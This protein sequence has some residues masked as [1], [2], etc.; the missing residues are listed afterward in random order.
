M[1]PCAANGSLQ[2]SACRMLSLVLVLFAASTLLAQSG[3]TYYVATNGSDGNPGTFA[4]PWLTVQHAATTATAGAT[5]YVMGGVYNQIVSFPNSGTQGSPITFQ[6]YPGQ[7][8][9]LDGTGLAVSGT[10]GLITISGAR[11]YITIS[12]FEIRNLSTT[13]TS[14]VPCG[15]WITGSGTGVQIQNNLIHNIVSPGKGNGCGLFAY[16]TSQT[17]ISGLIVNGNEL[18]DLQT[19]ESESMTLN[20]NVTNFQVTNNLVH[21]NY[22]IGIDIIGYE[23]TGPTGYD[24]AMLGVVSGN[25]VYNIS[26]IVNSGET[27]EYDADGLYCDGCAYVTWEK[28]VVFQTDYGIETTSENQL[29]GSNGTDWASGTIGVGTPA[30]GKLPCYGMYNTVRNNLFYEANSCGMSIGGYAKATTKGGGSN[31]GGSSYHDVFVNNTLY[32]NGAQPGNADEGEPSGDY[33]IQYQVGSAQADYFENNVIYS[34]SPNIWIND[35][36]NSTTQTTGTGPYPAPPATLNYNSYFSMAGYAE[37]TSIVWEAFNGYTNFANWQSVTGEDANSVNADPQFVALGAAPPDFDTSPGSPAIGAGSSTSI[38]CSVGWCDPNGSSPNSIYGSTDFL[39]NPRTNG[40][41]IDIGAYQNTGVAVSNSISVNLSSLAN[42]LE[43]GQSTTLT[44]TVTATPGGAGVPS[45][46]VNFMVGSTLLQT[47]TLFPTSANTSAASLPLNA[48]QLTP[49]TNQ[50]TAVYSG[51]SIAPCCSPTEPPGGSQTP[52]PVYP[53]A[54]SS[55]I[56]VSFQGSPGIYNPA[57]NTSL[58]GSSQNFQWF[59]NASATAYWLDIGMEQGGNEY[60]SSG[61]LSSSTLS[62]TANS[63]PLNGST[64]WARWYYLIGGS[65]QYTDYSYTALGASSTIA[66]ITSPVNNSTFTSSSATFT[67]NWVGATGYWINVGSTPGGNQYF[68]SGNLGNVLTKTVNGLPTNGSTVYVTL[69]SLNHGVWL[70]NAYTYTAYN[71]AAGDAVMTTPAPNSTLTGS[72]VTFDWTAGSGATAYWI[73]IGSS[74]G[75]NNY[76]SS[77]NLGNVLT[78]TVSG[79]PTNGNTLYVTLYSLIG[80]TWSPNAYTYTAF[81]ASSATGMVTTPMPGSTLTSSTVT[82]DWTAGS[83]GPYSYWMDVGNTAGGNNYYSSGNLGNVTTTTVSGLPT[84]GSM[85]YVTLYTLISGSWVGNAYT[86]TALNSTSGLA[87]M[88]TPT[89]GTTISGTTATFNWSGDSNATAY[90]V[91]IGSSAG[92]N[93]IYSSGNLGTA[94]TTT[95]TTLPANG[96]EI[97]VSLYSYVGGQWVNNPVTYTSGP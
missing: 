15:V 7:T 92:G 47:Q 78:D 75:G 29:C 25:T 16:G 4:A 83:P 63:L 26:G 45:G 10:Q 50:L 37:G 20:G 97:Y 68:Q 60:Y 64:I 35:Y 77:G 89:P 66:G 46:T 67:W 22:N 2:H 70:S 55:S 39:G 23:K 79:L 12:G 43:P 32:D 34:G 9:I 48:V 80:G 14:A 82:F 17:P 88:Q 72:T 61:S 13:K 76:Y 81:S 11:S 52:N 95:V 73:D 87:T 59:G 6:S 18:Y 31:G 85:I 69:Y 90:W 44:A 57:N 53:G 74:A 96:S 65:W 84:D 21:D 40:S 93:D 91:D 27:D 42:S 1:T 3:A 56:S 71:V 28:N 30:T 5:V 94:L 58:T 8:A 51:N 33:Q 24:Q 38:S 54:T 36:N 86:Y 49:G 19:G 41:T 62:Q